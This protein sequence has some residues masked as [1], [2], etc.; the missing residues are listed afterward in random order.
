MPGEQ[1]PKR[2][3]SELT[4]RELRH[5]VSEIQNTLWLVE[6]ADDKQR[7][8]GRGVHHYWKADKEWD[9]PSLLSEIA[10]VLEDYGLKPVDPPIVISTTHKLDYEDEPIPDDYGDSEDPDDWLGQPGGNPPT[11]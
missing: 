6:F 4:P 7:S 2:S 10:T 9:C 5:I 1:H 3:L 11:S 8:T